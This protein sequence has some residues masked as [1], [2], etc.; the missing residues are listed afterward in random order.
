MKKEQ[1]EHYGVNQYSR[2]FL[3]RCISTFVVLTTLLLLVHISLFYEYGFNKDGR[4]CHGYLDYPNE[5][6][7]KDAIEL[8][9]FMQSLSQTWQNDKKI[10]STFNKGFEESNDKYWTKEIDIKNQYKRN[11]VIQGIAKEFGLETDRLSDILTIDKIKTNIRNKIAFPPEYLKLKRPKRSQ[12]PQCDMTKLQHHKSISVSFSFLK[13]KTTRIKLDGLFSDGG[14][15]N[16]RMATTENEQMVKNNIRLNLTLYAQ[17]DDLF[18]TVSLSRIEDKETS[19]ENIHI[20]SRHTTAACLVYHLDIIFPTNLASYQ[21]FQLEANHANRVSGD[22]ESIVFK[23]FSVGLGRGAIDLK[24]IKGNNIIVGTLNG[25]ILGNYLPIEKFGAA[26]IQGA[27]MIKISPQSANLKSTVVT[28][29]GPVKVI[30][31]EGGRFKAH[32]WL[33]VPVIESTLDPK[34]IHLSLSRRKSVKTGYFNQSKGAQTNLHSR[35][36]EV[37]LI[38]S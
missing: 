19:A 2:T 17:T 29:D 30:V 26:A 35:Y 9:Q 7:S 15:I 32:C 10:Y 13:F 33:C 14:K 21:S 27:T 24:N 20:N 37:R 12:V 31:K 36:G 6:T 11:Q 8:S 5:I 18:N 38:Y 1:R 3:T 16:V 22:L 23:S 34:L 4:Q 28:L 25:I